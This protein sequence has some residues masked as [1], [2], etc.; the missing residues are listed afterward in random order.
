MFYLVS[1]IFILLRLY[2]DEKMPLKM[3]V[4]NIFVIGLLIFGAFVYAQDNT[5]NEQQLTAEELD[6]QQRLQRLEEQ[7]KKLEAES[8]KTIVETDQL[9]A[10]PYGR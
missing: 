10:V 7:A 8:K 4:K 6:R 3:I 2:Q 5:E 9:P 1:A